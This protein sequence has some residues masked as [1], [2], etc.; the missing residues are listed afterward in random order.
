MAKKQA[1]AKQQPVQPK[2]EK[3][4]AT[5]KAGKRYWGKRFYIP[6][7]GF[8]DVGDEASKEALSA[9]AKKTSLYVD[10]YLTRD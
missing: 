8:V 2:E 3:P 6:G 9:W 10:N 1:K 7:F 4:K 5:A